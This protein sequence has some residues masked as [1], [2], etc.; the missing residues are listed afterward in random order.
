MPL[1]WEVGE[2]V[3]EEE[4][5]EVGVVVEGRQ[6]VVVVDTLWQPDYRMCL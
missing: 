1:G 2:G 3:E 6:V 4:E 5:E